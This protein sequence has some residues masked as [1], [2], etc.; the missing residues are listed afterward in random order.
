MANG[1][2]I[3]IGAE[4]S[5]ALQGLQKVEAATVK[6]GAT[7]NKLPASINNT[8]QALKKLTPGSNEAGQSLINLSRVAQDAPYGF[9]GIA[10]NINPLLESF[11]RLKTSTGTTGGALKALGKE[12]T[13]GAG[14]GLAIGVASSLL[15]VFGDKLFGASK[16]AKEAKSASDALKDSISGIFAESAKEAANAAGF[17]AILKSETETRERKLSAIK[18]LQK[19]QPEIFANLKL[20]GNAVIGLDNAYKSYLEN[21]KTV[22]AV[23]I[24]QAQLEQKIAELLQKQGVTLT[25]SEKKIKDMTEAFK[26]SD[27][28]RAKRAGG[29][30]AQSYVEYLLGSEQKNKDALKTIENDI[31]ALIGDI[32]QLSKGV[33]TG[34]IKIKPDKIKFDFEGQFAQPITL[35]KPIPIQGRIF[36]FN[37]AQLGTDLLKKLEYAFGDRLKSME[38]LVVT[39]KLNISESVKEG[40]EKLLEQFKQMRQVAEQVAGSVSN[41]FSNAFSQ[42]A[43]GANVFESLGNAIKGVV[44]DLIQAAIKALIFKAVMNLILPGSGSA[45]A[46]LGSLVGSFGGFRAAGGPVGQG[47]SY[48]VGENGPELFVPAN[49]G[50][51]MNGNQVAAMSYSGG[52]S[53][54][55]G[56]QIVRGQ[57]IILAYAR[58]NRAQNRLGRG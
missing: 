2:D 31:N 16:A 47:Q 52:G 12:L 41:A 32:T 55:G 34:E 35:A 49:S 46:G 21:L 1:I 4:V 23:K 42:I 20:E 37:T 10:N 57:N 43:S 54:G 7:I 33:K 6:A 29:G 58:T 40:N 45:T 19:I 3:V 36:D 56:R 8:T 38:K 14:L 50:R 9:I 26:K 27:L 22:I 5:G 51:I 39:P 13:G 28:E 24:K 15:V 30:E 25:A 44:V 18:E 53:S 11:Q 17:V 48:V